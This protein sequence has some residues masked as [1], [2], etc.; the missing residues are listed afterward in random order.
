MR[1]S[2]TTGRVSA[3]TSA[4]TGTLTKKIHSQ[5]AYFVRM[6][7]KSTPAAAPLPPIAPQ[8]PSAL[9]RSEP[10]SNVVVMIDERRRRDD[11]GAD[12][13]HRARRDEH[14]D[15]AGEPARERRAENSA[16]P[17][18]E[19]APPAEQVGRAA[20]EQQEAAERDRVGDQHPLQ[21]V[22]G[23]V[24]RRLDRRQRDVDD[25]D[26]E[27]RH[28][29]RDADE[30]E[31]LPAARIGCVRL[32]PIVP[33]SYCSERKLLVGGGT[34][35][36]LDVRRDRLRRGRRPCRRAPRGTSGA[37]AARGRSPPRAR[38]PR[39]SGGIAAIAGSKTSLSQRPPPRCR[40]PASCPERSSHA[41]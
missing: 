40:R 6:P 32:P 22:L 28:E 18:H 30:R 27:H 12:A 39:S 36:V 24:Q 21:R 4:P 10:S 9:L 13:L 3:S 25:R 2:R 23:D 20:A 17:D 19:H 7:P 34:Q 29:E 38:R 11:R 14:A 26:V 15:R 5:P 35:H 1:L 31:R 8:M 41:R 37:R 33:R 16:T